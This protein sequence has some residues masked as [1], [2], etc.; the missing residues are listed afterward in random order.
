MRQTDPLVAADPAYIMYKELLDIV[1]KE[2]QDEQDEINSTSAA[3]TASN[4]EKPLDLKRLES[5]YDRD[6]SDSSD[7][8]IQSELDRKSPRYFSPAPQVS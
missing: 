2:Q 4:T 1:S 3:T 7:N 5:Q 6:D 8:L